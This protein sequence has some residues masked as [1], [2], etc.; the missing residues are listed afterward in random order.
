MTAIDAFAAL[1][2]DQVRLAAGGAVSGRAPL[3][4]V[5]RREV[6]LREVPLPEGSL[7]DVP[8]IVLSATSGLSPRLRTQLTQRHARLIATVPRGQHTIVDGAGHYIHHD[9]PAAVID[10]VTSVAA[11]R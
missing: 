9:R 7:P 10:A 1:V 5:P 2:P 4:E 11:G 3:R 8:V 6:P